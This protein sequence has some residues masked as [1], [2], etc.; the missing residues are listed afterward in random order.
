[1]TKVRVPQADGE[2]SMV[3]GGVQAPM[4]VS[5]KDGIAEVDD[6]YLAEFLRSVDGSI[7][8]TDP[9][10]AQAVADQMASDA[11]AV[12]AAAKAK[13]ANDRAVAKALADGAARALADLE[14]TA[15]D[16]PTS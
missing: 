4:T 2:I 1:M 16:K 13:A 9:E 6:A 14:K 8:V 12:A 3:P 5:V 15:P 10:T 7:A 11:K